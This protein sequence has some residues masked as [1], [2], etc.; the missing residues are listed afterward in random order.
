MSTTTEETVEETVETEETVEPVDPAE[1]SEEGFALYNNTLG[2]F[3]SGVTAKRPTKAETK[4]ATPDGHDVEV[5]SV[6]MR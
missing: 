1:Q 4:A 6:R 3:V 5:R 2:Q